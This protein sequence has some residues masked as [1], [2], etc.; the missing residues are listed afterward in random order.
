VAGASPAVT[1][2]P[3]STAVSAVLSPDRGLAEQ[4]RALKTESG[5]TW[6]QFARLFGVTP[7][8]VHFWVEGGRMTADNQRRLEHLR[9]AIT[10][11]NAPAPPEVREALFSIDP[12]GRSP[13]STL[14]SELTGPST[15]RR[16]SRS[17]LGAEETLEGTGVPGNIVGPEGFSGITLRRR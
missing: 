8:A 13:Y 4:V 7:R 17:P 6:A 3:A 11:I 15:R 16:S 5:L 12:A 10:T 9:E 14:I 1:V 2:I